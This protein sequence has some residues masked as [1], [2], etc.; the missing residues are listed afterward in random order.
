MLYTFRNIL[1]KSGF[2]IV[3]YQK[4]QLG[5][6]P[7]SDM[8]YFLRSIKEPVI[9]DVGA[10]EGQSASRFISDYSAGHVYSFE[11]SP[12]TY[13]ALC[14]NLRNHKNSHRFNFGVGSANEIRCLL[15]NSHP[16]MTSFLNPAESCWGSL[17][18]KTET[19]IVTL[20]DFSKSSG[21]NKIHIVKS[22]TQGFELEVFRGSENLFLNN[23]VYLL[24]FEIIFSRMYD[25]LPSLSQIFEFLS[26]HNFSLVAFYDFHFQNDLAAWSDV[27]FV[28]T[29]FEHSS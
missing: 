11:P 5:I 10:N 19:Q 20:D 1:R 16:T 15:E 26:K 28:N 8:R 12:A 3:R 9:F 17:I 2:D 14:K 7:F 23:R 27:L 21:I 29:K 13:S 18:R 25:N 24:Y 4:K 22:D 6:D